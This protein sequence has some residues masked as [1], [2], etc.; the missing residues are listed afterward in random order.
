MRSF[1]DSW[2]GNS[3]VCFVKI[4]SSIPNNVNS[5]RCYCDLYSSLWCI[6]P[7]CSTRL[8][9]YFNPLFNCSLWRHFGRQILA[10]VISLYISIYIC[11]RSYLQQIRNPYYSQQMLLAS[12]CIPHTYKFHFQFQFRT[13]CFF[14]F[15]SIPQIFSIWIHSLEFHI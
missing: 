5:P 10:W 8:A 15:I 6:I 13:G 2:F 14:H 7:S 9:T 1:Y 3:V 11:I 12:L 4:I